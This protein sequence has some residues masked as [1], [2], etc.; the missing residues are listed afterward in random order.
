MHYTGPRVLLH[1]VLVTSLP[2]SGLITL[3]NIEFTSLV[4]RPLGFIPPNLI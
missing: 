4:Q 3:E 2:L 1:E